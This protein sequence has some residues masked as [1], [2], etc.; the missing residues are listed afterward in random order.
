MRTIEL[1]V[2]ITDAAVDDTQTTI[3]CTPVVRNP[4]CPD[5][6]RDGRYRD[7]VTRP[8][9]DLPVAGRRQPKHRGVPELPAQQPRQRST[10]HIASVIPGLV[11]TVLAGEPGLAHHTKG[12]ANHCRGEVASES[13]CKRGPGVGSA[14]RPPSHRSER[15]YA[16]ACTSITDRSCS[17][18]DRRAVRLRS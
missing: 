9:T 4:R 3:F 14:S 16:R 17:R 13:R 8:L 10:G 11:A 15:T 1:G 7:T 2:T 12:D 5:C 6:G 18:Q